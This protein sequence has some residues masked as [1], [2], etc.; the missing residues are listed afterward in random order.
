[1][2]IITIARE[3]GA[4]GRIVAKMLAERTA[5]HFIDCAV[6][7]SRLEA[8]GITEKKRSAFDERRPG[9]FAAL[10]N[11][12]EEYVCCLKQ[13]M[14]EEAQKQGDCVILGRGSQVLFADVPGAI[15]VRLVASPQVRYQ[16]VAES[17]G[18]DVRQAKE[19]VDRIDHDRAGFN[20]YFFDTEWASPSCYQMV[21]NTEHLTP[22]NAVEIICALV[23]QTV[24]PEIEADANIMLKNLSRA[25][26]IEREILHVQRIPVFF[27]KVTCS[28]NQATL[29]GVAHSTDDIDKA[30]EVAIKAGME[31][32]D[33]RIEI[34]LHGQFD[35][36]ELRKM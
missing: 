24:T 7:D 31:R 23:K 4:Y 13:V 5:A 8:M 27:L 33:C 25:Q 2:A 9:F 6:V 11:A 29:A 32:V 3:R 10:T 22:E 17:E 21:L 16:R 36:P 35:S 12:G 19:L 14:Y 30:R 34:G 1:M 20:S 18:L 26:A 15:R 28:G